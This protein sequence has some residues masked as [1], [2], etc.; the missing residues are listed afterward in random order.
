MA[1]FSR[2]AIRYFFYMGVALFGIIYELFKS[3]FVRWPLL[4]GYA[5]VIGACIYVLA[6]RSH[7]SPEEEQ[8]GE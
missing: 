3:E 2:R 6:T 1:K 4:A 5:L 8:A 7:D